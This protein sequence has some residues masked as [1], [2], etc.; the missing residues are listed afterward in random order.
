MTAVRVLL[1]HNAADAPELVAAYHEVSQR[2]Q[3]MPGLLSNEL[4][5]SVVRPEGFVVTSTW[6]SM[7]DYLEWARRPDHKSLTAP[8][9][10]FRDMSLRRPFDVYQVTASY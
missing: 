5:Q 4:L 7:E 3:G 2:L 10:P 6:R 9:R 8:L 1:Y